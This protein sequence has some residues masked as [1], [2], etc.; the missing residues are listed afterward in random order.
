MT[1]AREA[2][3]EKVRTTALDTSSDSDIA[4][5]ADIALGEAQGVPGRAVSVS[6]L[7]RVVTLAGAVSTRRQRE[8]AARA[9]RGLAGVSAVW[10]TIV[11]TD[12]SR[13][14]SDEDEPRWGDAAAEAWGTVLS[15]PRYL[16][17]AY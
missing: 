1:P 15:P 14:A 4:E 8:A 2:P 9:L 10:N 5:R 16:S 13:S 3:V 7:A 6:V 17:R 11:L 12:P